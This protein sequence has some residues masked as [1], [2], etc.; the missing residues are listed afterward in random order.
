MESFNEIDLGKRAKQLRLEHNLTQDQVAKVL[1]ATPGYISNVENGRTAM[2]LRMLMY[3]ARL[4]GTTLDS[5]VGSMDAS[6][7]A[8]A[9]DN[10][11]MGLLEHFTDAEK[12]KLIKTIQMWKEK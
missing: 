7:T 5:L 11:I 9:L 8:T 4:T 3:F 12:R 1:H 2:S 10:E 6:Y